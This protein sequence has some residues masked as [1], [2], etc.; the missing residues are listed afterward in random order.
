MPVFV[1][2]DLSSLPA[3]VANRFDVVLL[4]RDIEEKKLQLLGLADRMIMTNYPVS[5]M[6]GIMKQSWMMW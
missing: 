6:N 3:V 5:T 2:R 1:A 4:M